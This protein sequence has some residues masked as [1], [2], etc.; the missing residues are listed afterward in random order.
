MDRA[1]AYYRTELKT[2]VPLYPSQLDG[3][4]DEHL[5]QNLKKKLEGKT[6]DAGIVIKVNR[7]LHYDYGMVEHVN[8]TGTTVYHVTHECYVCSPM[9]GLVMTCIIDNI[10][11]GYIIGSNG[12]MI[13]PISYNHINERLFKIEGEH[14]VHIESNKTLD[15]GD[16]LKV[17]VINTRMKLGDKN[18]KVQCKLLDLASKDDIS[19]F[20][21]DE[22]L[23]TDGDTFDDNDEFI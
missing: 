7:I 12:P 14:I 13:I 8:F 15:K 18:I 17:S 23:I 4:M 20:K 11:K 3:N 1:S 9:K 2:K 19:G 10:L 6:I 5:L 16:Y 21:N 22:A